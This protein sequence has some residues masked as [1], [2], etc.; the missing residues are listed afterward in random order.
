MWP[1]DLAVTS[2]PPV[3]FSKAI[4]QSLERLKPVPRG[5]GSYRHHACRHNAVAAR[6]MGVREVRLQACPIHGG[7][8]AG[9]RLPGRGELRRGEGG[10]E[11]L[12]RRI[13]NLEGF[14]GNASLTSAIGATARQTVE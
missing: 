12:L 14:R 8:Q 6:G 13:A 1:G 2:G 3:Q 5:I 10:R 9:G 7:E 4:R 11:R